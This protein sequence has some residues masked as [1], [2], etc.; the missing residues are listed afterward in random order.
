MDDMHLLELLH[1]VYHQLIHLIKIVLL[2]TALE[3]SDL[4]QDLLRAVRCEFVIVQ[5]LWAY[6]NCSCLGCGYLERVF[7]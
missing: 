1:L 6:Q 3:S 5:H 2:D 4:I 7:W